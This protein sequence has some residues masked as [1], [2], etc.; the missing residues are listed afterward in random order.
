MIWYEI[1]TEW[2]MCYMIIGAIVMMICI[3]FY[4]IDS[5]WDEKDS[6]MKRVFEFIVYSSLWL[7][8]VYMWV[9]DAIEFVHNW[10]KGGEDE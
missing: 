8:I 10:M 5:I 9:R 1:V 6:K 7:V 2:L 4:G 3:A